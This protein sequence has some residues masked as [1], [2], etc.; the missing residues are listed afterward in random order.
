MARSGMPAE[1]TLT[2]S[3]AVTVLHP[4]LSERQLRMIVRALGWAPAGWRHPGSGRGHPVA[5]Y[6][7]GEL[8]RLHAAL[9]PWLETGEERLVI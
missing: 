5:T 7:A 9:R 4:P 2:I 3:E 6:P 8:F 1:V